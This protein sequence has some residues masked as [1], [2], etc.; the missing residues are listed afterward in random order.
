MGRKIQ[1]GDIG[2]VYFQKRASGFR[3]AVYFRDSLGRRKRAVRSGKTKAAARREL[4]K[5]VELTQSGV[6]H[7]DVAAAMTLVEAVEWWLSDFESKVD[8]GERAE[9]TFDTYESVVRTHIRNALSDC[10]LD[11]FT[12]A[13]VD[14]Y[15]QGVLKVSG[16]AAAKQCRTV[17]SNTGSLLMRRGMISRNPVGDVP[18]L[19]AKRKRKRKKRA[20]TASQA[21][22]F[23]RHVREYDQLR[24]TDNYDLLMVLLATGCRV[25]EALALSWSCVDFATGSVQV[26]ATAARV[27]GRGILVGPTKSEAG[28][29]NLTLPGWCLEVLRDRRERRPDGDI[30][31][32]TT[33]GA[34]RDRSAVGKQIRA[35]R[36]SQ[37]SWVTSH[38]FRRTMATLMD[39]SG[40]S[41]RAVADQL[42]HSRISTTLDVYMARDRRS[43][44]A[45]VMDAVFG[46]DF[47]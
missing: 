2:D 8:R 9:T 7:S 1:R 3:A 42:G 10:M 24:G 38:T 43:D 27:K 15:L 19:E 32:P 39:D 21:R 46:G 37:W 12:P 22:A 28:E 26:E 18:K 6:T 41:A 33:T 40:A 14:T 34:Y 11:D 29:R 31:F 5:H 4:L 47:D 30:I 25:G 16:Y 23:L 17:L 44:A 45:Q 36:G 13:M 20:L 35:M